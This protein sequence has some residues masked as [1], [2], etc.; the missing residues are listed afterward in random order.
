[1]FI[2]SQDGSTLVNVE[3]TYALKVQQQ[4]DAGDFRGKPWAV[5][6]GTQDGA[7]VVLAIG[8][9]VAMKDLFDRIANVIAND[10]RVDLLD[11]APLA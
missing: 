5:I 10:R 7:F 3:Q 4:H 8:A 9:E 11:L 6:A 2:R 1:M